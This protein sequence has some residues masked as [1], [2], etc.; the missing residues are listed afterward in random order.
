MSKPTS[1][2]P[3]ECLSARALAAWET[4]APDWDAA[5]TAYGNKYW[6]RL[7]EPSLTRLLSPSLSANP[8]C[9]ALDLATG[10][11][12][13]ARWLR[14]RGAGSVLATDGSEEM[15]ELARGHGDGDVGIMF[16]KVD[17]TREKNLGGLVEEEAH[18][19]FDVVL[20]NMAIMDVADLE[21][22]A[23]ALKGGLLAQ[24]GV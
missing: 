17:V 24:D 7:Q 6:R 10:N 11:G 3:I 13:C 20:M 2:E 18:G 19:G 14:A 23:K 16:R 5:I 1:S 8:N 9:R 4:I 22:L 12:L 15:L 21:P